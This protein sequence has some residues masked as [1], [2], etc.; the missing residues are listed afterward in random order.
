MIR[1]QV[2]KSFQ[3]RGVADLPKPQEMLMH[4]SFT[5]KSKAAAKQNSGRESNLRKKLSTAEEL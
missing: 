1:Q 2:W 5:K 3:I 4:F